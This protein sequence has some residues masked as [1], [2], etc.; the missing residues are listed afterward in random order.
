MVADS[1]S[2]TNSILSKLPATFSGVTIVDDHLTF[3]TNKT[4][5]PTALQFFI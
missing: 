4:N 5:F 2:F 1:L 3:L